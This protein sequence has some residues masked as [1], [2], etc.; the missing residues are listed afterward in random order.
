MDD[1]PEPAPPASVDA[2]RRRLNAW[3]WRLPVLLATG[4]AGFGVYEAY[5][6]H[7]AK[8]AP[9][10]PPT[11]TPAPVTDV[12][13]L[14]RFDAP[15]AAVP[16]AVAGIPSLAIRVPEPVPGGTTAS[17][18]DGPMHLVAFSRVCTHLH[19][20]VDL[21]TDLELVAFAFNYRSDRPTLTCGCHLSVFD[22]LRAGRAVSG[23]A[24]E[25][26][27]RVRL[28]VRPGDAEGAAQVVAD[29]VETRA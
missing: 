13:P 8:L 20:I 24:V 15:W 16:F 10:D 4:G 19:C 18:A 6:I 29:A 2:D 27:P 22:V 9:A 25:P 3:L 7:F 11:F 17:S 14:E 12:A 23:P 5:R 28:S 26:L 21:N 1:A